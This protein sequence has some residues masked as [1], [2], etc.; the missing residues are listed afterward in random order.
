MKT[1]VVACVVSLSFATVLAGVKTTSTWSAPEHTLR[2][3]TKVIALAKVEEDQNRRM[4]EDEL[5]E[6][7]GKHKVTAV[8][9]YAHMKPEELATPEAAKAKAEQ[10]GVDAALVVTVT[11]RG[12]KVKPPSSV[13]VGVGVPVHV[14]MFSV[15][16]G[17]SKPIGGGAPQSIPVFA[18]KAEFFEKGGPQPIWSATYSVELASGVDDAAE[19]LARLVTKQLKKAKII[20]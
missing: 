4:V 15:F 7:F 14:G 13:S 12:T 19:D 10:L 3:Y 1:A 9:A 17:G 18:M 11:E 8:P 6:A 5:V 16:V 20:K 2:P